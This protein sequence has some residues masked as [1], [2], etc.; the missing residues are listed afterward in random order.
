MDDKYIIEDD[1]EIESFKVKTFSGFK[2]TDVIKAVLKSIESKKIEQ[3]CHWTTECIISGYII[4]LLEKLIIYSSKVICVNNP[5]L[6]ISEITR[7][8]FFFDMSLQLKIAL[9][10][11][12]SKIVDEINNT[13]K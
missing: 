8:I 13:I 5:K 4:Q 6:P 3:V 7:R 9:A 10:T 11:K 12:K 2:R 1:R